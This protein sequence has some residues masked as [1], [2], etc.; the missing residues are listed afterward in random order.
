MSK[1]GEES[2]TTFDDV[3]M[4]LML[5]FLVMSVFSNTAQ[6][7][8]LK[9]TSTMPPKT[10]TKTKKTHGDYDISI[11]VNQNGDITMSPLGGTN[12]IK[13]KISGTKPTGKEWDLETE[14]MFYTETSDASIEIKDKIIIYLKPIEG[15]WQDL[16]R[17]PKAYLT[18]HSN[19]PFG[20]VYAVKYAIFMVN[21]DFNPK[22]F[23]MIPCPPLD[24]PDAILKV[25]DYNKCI[26]NKIATQKS[27]EK[28][29]KKK[30]NDIKN[31]YC[32]LKAL[33][34]G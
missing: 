8:Y 5:F 31:R 7:Y 11:H 4:S 33:M 29:L 26:H 24:F 9:Q 15:R 10:S 17:R 14:G 18:A 20:A 22:K 6:V 21:R 28:K 34:G 25:N 3:A 30:K 23:K 32:N 2:E 27:C 19:A 13:V 12:K 1:F 16:K